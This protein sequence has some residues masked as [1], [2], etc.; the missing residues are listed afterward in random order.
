MIAVIADD[1]TG[2]AEIAGVAW[3]MGLSV[4]IDMTCP[5][6]MV[7][8]D[9]LV[10]ATD[11]R[12]MQEE[13]ASKATSEI[14]SQLKS[15]FPTFSNLHLFKKTDSALR[16][17]IVAELQ[18]LMAALGMNKAL[19][20][21]Q[22]PSKGR[23]IQD[24]RYEIDGTPL[25]ETPFRNDPEFPAWTSEASQLLTNTHHLSL[26]S[27]IR[28]GI[29][30]ADATSQEDIFLQLNK[31]D[32]DTLLA[33]AAD[34]FTAFIQQF[35]NNTEAILPQNNRANIGKT[36]LLQ[37]S[38]QSAPFGKGMKEMLMPDYVFHGDSPQK[39]IAELKE[40]FKNEPSMAIRI[41]QSS[42]GGKAYATRLRRTMAEAAKQILAN[43]Q[44][45]THVL[46]EGGATA[47]AVLEKLGW[48]SLHVEK[49]I[50]PGIVTLSHKNFLITLKPGSYSWPSGL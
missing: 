16:G 33:G 21:A 32:K 29:N 45:P 40:C 3:R 9:V 31:A 49:E 37:G 12:Q 36:V 19:L 42:E 39:W 35:T 10:I 28:E 4:R 26:G 25:D 48:N 14:V 17:N 6:K 50:A 5:Q 2:A 1:L 47:F 23:V 11:T 44:T 30:V 46:I 27:P 38:T 22:N 8:S 7:A 43:R 13:E 24:G 20:L 18:T 15:I 34:L 41:P